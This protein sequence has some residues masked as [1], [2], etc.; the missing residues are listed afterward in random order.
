MTVD[1]PR[2][3]VGEIGVGIDVVQ[4]AGFDER[5]GDGPAF[6][7]AVG[8]GEEGVLARSRSSRLRRSRLATPTAPGACSPAPPPRAAPG[9]PS[10]GATHG[11]SRL[12]KSERRKAGRQGAQSESQERPD[13][14]GHRTLRQGSLCCPI[15]A[16]NAA[17]LTDRFTSTPAERSAH[18]AVFRCHLREPAKTNPL[19]PF[20]S[21]SERRTAL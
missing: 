20:A 14:G 2:E 19:L 3:R 15:F 1:D 5:G 21:I 16:Y 18:T 6:R 17:V 4:F 11:F 13:M 12:P 10:P 8:P 9:P 7:A